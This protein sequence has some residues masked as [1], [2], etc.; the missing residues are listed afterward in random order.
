MNRP[1]G[2]ASRVVV[3]VSDTPAGLAA[4]REGA[5]EAR[6]RGISSPEASG[7]A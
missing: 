7:S 2:D 5:R 4:L 1:P 3:G 6:A